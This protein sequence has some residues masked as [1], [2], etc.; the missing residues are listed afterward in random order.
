MKTFLYLL[1]FLLGTSLRA[2]LS[3]TVTINDGAPAS[4]TNFTS[5]NSLAIS[6]NSAGINGPLLVN[7]SPGSGP[8]NEQFSLSTIPGVS[9]A[10]SITI[11]GNNCTIAYAPA[12]NNTAAHTVLLD[13]TDHIKFRNLNI[14]GES[15]FSQPLVLI[16]SADE[17]D[18]YQCHIINDTSE[19]NSFRWCIQLGYPA[20]PEILV[21]G[22]NGNRFRNC[23]TFGGSGA[24]CIVSSSKQYGKDNKLERCTFSDF[25][26]QGVYLRNQEN[27]SVKYCIVEQPTAQKRHIVTGMSFL[28]CGALLCEGNRIQ[29]L[30]TC[31]SLSSVYSSI[32]CITGSLQIRGP[33]PNIFRN[34]IISCQISFGRCT[35]FDISEMNAQIYHNTICMNDSTFDT[36]VAINLTGWNDSIKVFNN[37]IVLGGKGLGK[38]YAFYYQCPLNKFVSGN[39]LVYLDSTGNTELR[40]ASYCGD[41]SLSQIKSKGLEVNTLEQDPQI[42]IQNGCEPVP[43]NILINDKGAPLGV[44]LDANGAAR[45]PLAPDIGAL[46][47]GVAASIKENNFSNLRVFPNPAKGSLNVTF[48]SSQEFNLLVYDC[49]GKQVLRNTGTGPHASINTSSLSPGIYSLYDTHSALSV[50]IV[51]E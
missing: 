16:N 22:G 29:N 31:A 23:S 42:T 15:V 46:E 12:S 13:G 26:T 44:M 40:V 38:K 47:F 34:N 37:L 11:N 32:Y 6:L 21:P 19:Q 5:F 35:G 41:N 25:S 10:D 28:G 4:T 27:A 50:K 30:H 20:N 2:Q 8:Y 18:F 14:K 33:V 43:T 1:A 24:I 45:N 48:P 9:A 49:Y 17:N 51:V 36:S 39:N 3:G 7:V